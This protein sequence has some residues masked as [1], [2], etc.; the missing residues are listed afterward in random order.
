MALSL[1]WRCL[2]RQLDRRLF[3]PSIARL[4]CHGP[5]AW[6]LSAP[7]DRR[8]HRQVIGGAPCARRMYGA[9]VL[10][11]QGL[12]EIDAVEGERRAPGVEARWHGARGKVPGERSQVGGAAAPL[13]EVAEEE[14][15]PGRGLGERLHE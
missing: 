1:T 12:R 7:A 9:R 5:A 15:G 10:E 4:R 13:V 3:P 2:L 14:G 11:R 8:H 6:G